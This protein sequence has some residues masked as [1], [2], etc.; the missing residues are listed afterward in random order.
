MGGLNVLWPGFRFLG[1]GVWTAWAILAFSGT[2][3]LSDSEIDGRHISSLYLWS[4]SAFALT[5]LLAPL[6]RQR[7]EYFFTRRNALYL[8]GL[9]GSVGAALIILAGPYYL[10]VKPLFYVGAIFTGIGTAFVSLKCGQLYGEELSPGR[11]IIYAMISQL[12]AAALFFILLHA[13]EMGYAPIAG[14]P[15]LAG[16]LAFIGLPFLAAM[17]VAIN[18]ERAPKPV[19]P[20]REGLTD[21]TEEAIEEATPLPKSFW[22]FFTTIF[23]LTITT[24]MVH[25]LSVH[26][27]TPN[28]IL[29][30]TNIALFCRIALAIVSIYLV[31]RLFKRIDF[32]KL[33]FLLMVIVAVVITLYALIQLNGLLFDI[34]VKSAFDFFTVILWCLL[35]SVVYQKKLSPVVVFGFGYGIY[36]VGRTIGWTSG[37]WLLPQVSYPIA[38]PIILVVLALLILICAVVVFSEKDF[39]SLFSLALGENFTLEELPRL[40]SANGFNGGNGSDGNG[41]EQEDRGR[42]YM[43]ACKRVGSSA[44]LSAREKDVFELLA[45]GRG[46]ENIAQRLSIS[47]NTA[48]THT[49]NIY[50]KLEVHSRSELIA[51]VESEK[52]NTS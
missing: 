5:M 29:V 27:L 25:G 38:E 3:W 26:T 16:I 17:I 42:P 40:H 23:L 33:Y 51:L 30:G 11:I 45:L 1:L 4:S 18:C 24:S 43:E 14:G 35:A 44:R 31:V 19:K 34:I 7:V 6:F 28:E 47:L 52:Q 39:D 21:S 50:A 22:K 2:F 49:H 20:L 36:M 9:L 48:R 12:L 15:S 10:A 41:V 13:A 46:I 8:F 37:A 32:G